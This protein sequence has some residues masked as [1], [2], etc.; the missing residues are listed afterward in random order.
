MV[1]NE[2]LT[3]YR[4]KTVL[5]TGDTGFKGSWLSIWLKKM[6]A[7]VIGFGQAPKTDKDNYTI[8]GLERKITHIQGDIRDY[9][10]LMDVVNLYQPS[11]VFH[12]AAQALVLDSYR[13]PKETFDTNVMGT[14]NI[15][16]IVR[17]SPSVKA[18]VIVTS[19]KCYENRNWHFGYRESDPLG[20][21]DPYSAS[22]GA[23]EIVTQSYIRSFFSK[24]DSASVASVRAGNVLGGGDW[25]D[26]RIVPDCMRALYQN[27]PIIIRNPDAVRPWQH[28]LEPLYGYL[29]LG[30]CLYDG[31]KSFSGAWNFGPLHANMIS[32]R[33]LVDEILLQWGS[34]SCICKEEETDGA[35]E[36]KLLMLDISKS[37]HFLKWH[38]VL[39]FKKTLQFV[40]REYKTE[41]MSYEKI[42][43]QRLA[44]IEMYLELQKD[45]QKVR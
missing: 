24:Q 5:I 37:V 40:L 21:S 13:E 31:K 12:L 1:N 41:D 3:I 14:V 28:V 15:L 45:S 33:T 10:H 35:K 38:P 19:D 27:R 26:N 25:S 17:Q 36:S 11:I 32:V 7:N 23:A 16:E 30:S 42:F 44:D 20:G 22:K 9:S 29:L 43:D 18:A 8:C 34:G 2:K 6:G 39:N 4:G